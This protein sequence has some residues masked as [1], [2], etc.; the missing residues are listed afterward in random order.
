MPF[1]VFLC[2]QTGYIR[3]SEGNYYIE[4]VEKLQDTSLTGSILHRIRKVPHKMEYSNNVI[5]DALNPGDC[6]TQGKAFKYFIYVFYLS[7]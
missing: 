3:T 2:F 7:S 5:S 4:P 6:E 1:N